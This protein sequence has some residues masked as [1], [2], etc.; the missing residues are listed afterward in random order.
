[1]K[2]QVALAT[3][4]TISGCGTSP[5]VDSPE[6]G[7]T[8]SGGMAGGGMAAGGATGGGKGGASGAGASG[9]TSGG[10][11][12][13][14][15]TMSSGGAQAG[16]AAGS[17]SGAAGAGTAGTAG[18][19]GSAGNAGG[20][21]GDAGA[22]SGGASAGTAG[23]GAGGGGGT[24]GGDAGNGG[25][26]AG[27]GGSGGAGDAVPSA[28]CNQPRALQ[29][30]NLTISSGGQN[31]QYHVKTPD[32]YD[33]SHPYRVIF[34]FHWNY[35]SIN[36]IVNPPDADQNTDKPYYGLEEHSG[37]TTIFVVPQGLDNGWAN[38][39][40]RDVNFTDAMLTAVSEGL[41]IDESRVF[42]TGFSYGGAISMKLACSRN[43]KF[44]AAIVYDTGTFLSGFNR[45]ECTEPIAFFESHGLDDT[46]FNY[47]EGLNVLGIFT[48]LNGCTDATPP[49]APEDGH[50]CMSFEGCSA[51]NPVRFCNFGRGQNNPKPGGPGGHYPSPKDPGEATSWVPAEAWEF[52][53]Q[54]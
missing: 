45:N 33:Q 13:T 39:N 40:D 46:V 10:S 26:G 19:A 17:S 21:A 49:M 29:D 35:G 1:M 4:L 22:S 37:D 51:G 12:A 14:A 5:P 52:I 16:G 8:S 53:T 18:A 7:G 28:G 25:A 54:F 32:N 6:S 3:L 15:G 2:V 43:D 30:G 27:A 20:A 41:C 23:G 50:V 31:R 24:A 44:R 11:G 47:Q 42:T 9:G 48:E 36:A 34:M 38:P